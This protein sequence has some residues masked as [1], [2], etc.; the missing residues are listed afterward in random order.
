MI[1]IW[2]GWPNHPKFLCLSFF[3]LRSHTFSSTSDPQFP[4]GKLC[5]PGLYSKF[6]QSAPLSKG[7]SRVEIKYWLLRSLC[8]FR[9]RQFWIQRVPSLCKARSKALLR[10]THQLSSHRT[11]LSQSQGAHNP[12][13]RRMSVAGWVMQNLLNGGICRPSEVAQLKHSE[14]IQYVFRL[15]VPMDDWVGVEIADRTRDL[16]EIERSGV[17]WEAAVFPDLSKETASSGQLEQ[18]VDSGFITEAAIEL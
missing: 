1:I 18:Q 2:R 7:T 9:F 14:S 5:A 17:F 6:G 13:C 8:K 12:G 4:R 11:S 3:P 15:N 16:S 10:T